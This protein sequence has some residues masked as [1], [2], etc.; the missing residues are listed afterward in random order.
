MSQLSRVN[1][2][3]KGVSSAGLL[4]IKMNLRDEPKNRNQ[5]KSHAE[6]RIV[7]SLAPLIGAL[8]K[9]DFCDLLVQFLCHLVTFDSSLMLLYR[10]GYT[11]QILFD[12]LAEGDREAFYGYYLPSAYLLSPFY[13][14]WQSAPHECGAHRLAEIAPDGFF[15]S[16]YYTDYY[17]KSNIGDELGF[18]VPLDSSVAVLVSL[19][20]TDPLPT[21][22]V[23]ERYRLSELL[24]FMIQMV[25]QHMTLVEIPSGINMKRHLTDGLK[26]FGSSRLTDREQGV[27]Q[28][29][30]RG[31]S[32]KSCAR[33]LGISPTTERVHRRNIYSKLE[34]SSQAE[35]FSLFFETLASDGLQPGVD[36]L[37]H[38]AT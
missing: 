33:V 6:I 16:V 1:N 14:H 37:L 9:S 15:D 29:M 31:H 3:T 12:G 11:P 19:G 18:I 22:S 5:S 23:E 2:L 38:P 25:R 35:L 4:T 21:Y 26:L 24:P 36:P 20:R 34:I 27:V 8:G 30:L 32:S 7:A 28:M 10:R 13:L 17:S